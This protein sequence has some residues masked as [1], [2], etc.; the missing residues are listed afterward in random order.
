LL[1]VGFSIKDPNQMLYITPL[2]FMADAQ[3]MDR[4]RAYVLDIQASTKMQG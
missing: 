3:G 1:R 2:S 4:R